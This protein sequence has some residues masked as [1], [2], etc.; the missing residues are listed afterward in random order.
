MLAGSKVA[1]SIFQMTKIIVVINISHQSWES[2]ELT[3]LVSAAAGSE[4]ELQPI[5]ERE[6]SRA[7]ARASQLQSLILINDGRAGPQSG[8][9]GY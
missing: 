8:Q 4:L 3:V 2:S 1:E 9:A 7:T 5:T 6:S